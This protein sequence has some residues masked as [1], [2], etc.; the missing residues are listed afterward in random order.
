MT[1]KY[2]LNDMCF[3]RCLTNDCLYYF[4]DPWATCDLFDRKMNCY[5]GKEYAKDY[6][7]DNIHL[8][9]NSFLIFLY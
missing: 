9:I 6:W 1:K 5:R 2:S 7:I 8:Q 3:E 4:D